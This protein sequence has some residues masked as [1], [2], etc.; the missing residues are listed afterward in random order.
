M[1]IKHQ[2]TASILDLPRSAKQVIAM[3]SDTS[4]CAICVMAAFY[5]RLEQFVPLQGPVITAAWVSVVLAI[6][7]FWLS[8]LYRTIFRYS[9]SSIILSVAI[10]VII[11]GL[12]YFCVFGLYRVEGVSRSIGILQPMLL[13][14]A[15]SSS[16][17]L[18]KFILETS[19]F[20]KKKLI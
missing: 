2:L 13:F 12:L 4:L 8:G 3:I 18:V 14:F 11:Y 15:V 1:S 16:R 10:A 6:P 20:K 5:L 19:I 17:L 9:G 7:I